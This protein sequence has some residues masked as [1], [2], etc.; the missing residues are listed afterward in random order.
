MPKRIEPVRE[1]VTFFFEDQT[2]EAQQGE[3]V[4]SALAAT[5]IRNLRAS[6]VSGEPR[7]IFC[8]M[9]VCFDCLV[10][11]DGQP[12][13]QACMIPVS[14]DLQVKRQSGGVKVKI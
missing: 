11:I 2:I 10:E 8:M 6:A 14:Q 3:S 4:A 13:Q 9:G 7:G 1:P 5:G 12:N